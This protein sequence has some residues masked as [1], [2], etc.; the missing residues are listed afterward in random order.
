[1]PNLSLKTKMSLVVSLLAA[2]GLSLVTL[3]ASWYFEKQFKDTISRQQFTMVSAMAEEIDSKLRTAQ[4]QLLTVASTLTPAIINNPARAQGFLDSRPDTAAMFDSGVFLFSPQ[5]N[6]LAITPWELLLLHRNYAYRE[7][8]EETVKT[9]KPHISKPFF[10]TQKDRPPIIMFTAPVFDTKGKLAGILAGSLNLMKENFLGKLATVNIGTKGY[11][12]LYNTGRTIIVH[13][14]RSRILKNDVPVG[15]NK[16]FDQAIKGFEGTG[17]TVNSKGVS[18]LSTFKRL[19]TT[20]W[21]LA[22]NY[23]QSEA[24]S[25]IYR[26][27]WYM[28]VLF[29]G[30]LS[31]SILITWGFMR[32]LT[33][34][35]LL[36]TR[37]V[38]QITG[39]EDQLE[40][41]LVKARDEI[42]TL[43]QAFNRMVTEVN[44][45][46]KAVLEQK[47]F[48]TNLLEFSAVPTFVLDS[49]HRVIVWN[50]ACEELTGVK[51]SNV[52]GTTRQWQPFYPEKRPV[53]ADIVLDSSSESL[54]S[55]YNTYSSSPFSPDVLQAE[56]WFQSHNGEERFIFFEAAPVRNTE[57]TI[58]AAIQTL[59]D[60]T[61]RKRTE[62]SLRKL[63]LAIEQTPT[64]V[65]ITDREGIIEYVNPH[66][67]KVTGF[68]AEE[69]I[70]RT[71]RI[72]KSGY[73]SPEFY[74]EL[75]ETILDGSEWHGEF[76]N[77]RK[78]G[79]LYWEASTISPVKNASGA[80]THFVG[81][82]EDISGRKWAEEELKRSDE[83]I[84][85]LLESTAEAI[86]GVNL[87]GRCTFANPS[88]A[89]LL[90]Y[91]HPDELLGR[92]I[93]NLIHHTRKDGTPYPAEECP[94]FRSI[95]EKEGFHVEGEFLWRADG[96]G[97]PAEYWS[98]PQ[99]SGDKVVGAVVTFFDITERKQ[100]EEQLRQ[101]KTT[102]EAATRAKSE[103][104]ANMSHEIRTPMNA[105]I[106]MLYLLQQTPLADKQKN[107]LSKAQSAANSLLR[108]INDILDFSKI[109][110]GKLDLETEPFRLVT[111]L[112]NL[113]DMATATIK[114]KPVELLVSAGPDVPG[115]LIGDPLRLGQILLNLTNN[116][117]KFTEEGK[118]IV[119]V[120]TVARREEEVELRF[121]VQD[122][123]IGMTREQQ[124]RLFTA[125]TQAD[126]STTRRYGGTGL[127]LTI[128]RQLVEMMGGTLSVSSEAGKGS[129]FSFTCRFGFCS[130]E[131]TA[132]SPTDPER[133]NLAAFAAPPPLTESFAGVHILLVEDNLINQEVAREIFEGRGV[134]VDIANNGA[135][136]VELVFSS[137]SSYD[138]VFMDVQMPV[139]DGL[140]ATRR[141]RA[142]RA[143]DSLPII[144]MTASAMSSDRELCLLAGMNDQVTKPVDVPQLFATLGRWVSTEAFSPW[145][146]IVTVPSKASTIPGI[147][148]Q[149]AV[150]R[151]GSVSFLKSL[152]RSFRKEN[153]ETIDSIRKAVANGDKQ[154]VLRIV[155]TVKG[156][157]SNLGATELSSAALAF[158][159]AMNGADADFQQSSLEEFELKLCHVLNS[160]RTM[161]EDGPAREPDESLVK[162]LSIDRERI[163]PL[164]RELARLLETNSMAAL[165]VWEQLNP[166][167]AG[168]ARDKLDSAINSLNFRD[169]G[170]ILVAI[171]EDIGIELS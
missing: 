122:T 24:Y 125:F 102:A 62:E 47:E 85:L 130:G 127:G 61:E 69:A 56:R 163:G 120:E 77:K 135:E 81:V 152:L 96:T 112:K 168:V 133:D 5:G 105:A 145:E 9:G 117:V 110:A 6:L 129:V 2:V 114:E 19:Q 36:F 148:L 74:Q 126:T 80:I 167:L 91:N 70:G 51:A 10:S 38:E 1:M 140:E 155:H 115:H 41:I 34:P 58:I 139:M 4:T 134:T 57:G 31:L 95:H 11:L 142:D 119:S 14:D 101:A 54:S 86:Y 16:L 72:V 32:H 116:A 138:A 42:G 33:A 45:Q 111:V 12:Y 158:E 71:Q 90:G 144:A 153:I 60:I 67:T 26:V 141:I 68:A 75:W 15:A 92:N 8:I 154:L 55:L 18:L 83:Q 46:K 23:P 66:Y 89:R 157:G 107:Y 170:M 113:A 99:R 29:I 27:K 146:S 78:N 65:V 37:H 3:A 50:R 137:G 64:A 17:E 20:N 63:S 109:E 162:E 53:L 84:R 164:A 21:I 121:Y 13:P 52:I 48:S 28:L 94:M 93:H 73:H 161:E 30:M 104:L 82:K 35:L 128:A 76:R 100:A 151:L 159:E 108:V 88:C 147:D 131:D 149:Q 44:R 166:L 123:G 160:I 98:Y 103:F 7:Y 79:D 150:K 40:P 132:F 39:R 169:G 106:G 87:L 136:A 171:S 43:A 156:V 59:Q 118:V 143:F 49:R 22:A 165:G 97:F 124:A 25:P